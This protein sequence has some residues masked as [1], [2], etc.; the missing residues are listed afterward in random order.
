MMGGQ[1][2]LGPE[3]GR[4]ALPRVLELAAKHGLYVEVVAF[5]GTADIPV[6]LQAHID[7]I[8]S[9]LAAHPERGAGNRQ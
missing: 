6:D 1:F 9:I 8:A 4:R 5:A 3:D 2:D 7:G